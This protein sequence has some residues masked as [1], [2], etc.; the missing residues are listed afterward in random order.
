MIELLGYK[1][2]YEGT[3]I[4][5]VPRLTIPAGLHLIKGKNGSGKTT[6]LKSIA[7]II[8]YEGT[9]SIRGMEDSRST[10]KKY[11]A[12]VRYSPAE[13]I[14][15]AYL[16]GKDML[17]FY[18]SIFGSSDHITQVIQSLGVDT[19]QEQKIGN[20]SSGM[21]KKLSIALS[22]MGD[23]KVIILDE[24]YNALDTDACR[25]LN[26]LIAEFR[27][28][29]RSFLLTS[30]QEVSESKWDGVFKVEDHKITSN[31]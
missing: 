12:L 1:K 24:P 31:A 6:L 16:K 27:S 2:S 3:P 21:L 30:H 25:S 5:D 19:F 7:G 28:E 22:F 10:A 13:P 15:P 20:Y 14:F 8:P 17:D 26:N 29:G 9:I 4:L 23:S 18:R 11:R